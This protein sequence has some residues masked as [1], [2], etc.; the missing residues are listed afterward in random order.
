[1]LFVIGLIKGTG[2]LFSTYRVCFAFLGIPAL[3]TIA[4]VG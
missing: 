1:M 4:L 3:I 2:N